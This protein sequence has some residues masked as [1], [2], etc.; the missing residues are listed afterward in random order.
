ML[1]YNERSGIEL[2]AEFFDANGAATPPNT[3]H[4][5][6]DCDTTRRVLQGDT[7]EDAVFSV[8]TDGVDSWTARIEIPGAL[9]AIQSQRNATELKKLLVIANKDTATEY[10]QEFSYYVKNLRGRN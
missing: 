5:R 6:L 9:N 4:W 10:S 1:Q 7:A 3:V 8:N 2:D